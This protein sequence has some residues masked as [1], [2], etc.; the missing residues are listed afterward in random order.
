M[1]N[2]HEARE[3]GT[4]PASPARS[5]LFSLDPSPARHGSMQARAGLGQETRHG[6]LVRHGPFNSKPVKPA[7]CTKTC[8]PARLARFSARFFRVPARLGPLRVRLGQKTG[9]STCRTSPPMRTLTLSSPDSYYVCACG[10]CPIHSGTLD[11]KFCHGF[12]IVVLA[13]YIVRG[14]RGGA[15][16]QKY[17]PMVGIVF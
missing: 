3:P 8:L 17:P 4:R 14:R 15:K 2:K 13:L 9:F 7:F 1:T 6:G 12:A 10:G 11:L 5:P 16:N